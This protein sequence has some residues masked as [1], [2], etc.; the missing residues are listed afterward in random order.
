MDS[1]LEHQATRIKGKHQIDLKTDIS[2]FKNQAFTS[3]KYFIKGILHVFRMQLKQIIVQ[4][5]NMHF[6]KQHRVV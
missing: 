4:V 5:K 1:L 3:T 2:E 6:S